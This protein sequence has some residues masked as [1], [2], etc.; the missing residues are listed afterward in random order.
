MELTDAG[1]IEKLLARHRFRSTRT[2]GQNFLAAAWVPPRIAEEA[3]ITADDGV[4]EV[5]PGLGALTAEL[6]RRARSV[7]AVELDEKLAPV[8]RETLGEYP[9]VSVT[10]GDALKLD[11]PALCAGKLGARPWKVC[12]NIPYNVTTPLLTAF[13]TAGCFE[14]ITVMVQR[15]AAER[16]MAAPGTEEYGAF[17]ARVNWDMRIERLFDVPPDCFLPRPRVTSTVI[18]LQKREQLPAVLRDEALFLRVIRAA[19]ALRRKT[20]PN[21]LSAGLGLPRERGEA[22]LA[23]LGL[24]PRTRGETLSPLQFALLANALA[25]D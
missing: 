15:E 16:L 22:A 6:A 2:M 25:E 8:L 17:T 1:E 24:D 23:A 9:S 21:A 20:L 11:L 14:T 10:Y 12:A 13:L 3:G 18:R 19:F 4:L 5:G 7:A